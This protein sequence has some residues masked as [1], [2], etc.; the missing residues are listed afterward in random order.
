MKISRQNVCRLLM[1][2]QRILL[3]SHQS[4]D[5][6]TLGSAYAMFYAL[7][8]LGKQ[9]NI[10]CS[11]KI[12]EKYD[13]MTSAAVLDEIDPDLIVAVD[14]ADEGLF[15]K[16]LEPY[17]GRVDLCIDH[18]PSNTRYAKKILLV[19]SASAVCEII[20][21]VVRGMGLEMDPAIADCLYTGICTDTGCFRYANVTPRTHRIAA[22][23]MQAGAQSAM[24]NQIMFDTKSRSRIMLERFA[25]ESIE[26]FYEGK[27]AAVTVSRS[28]ME[29]SGADD[30]DLDGVSS[31]P[32]QIEGVLV[33]ITVRE[34]EPES[35][36]ISIRTQGE[37]NASKI[38]GLF[39]G[40][41]HK[42]AAGCT[43]AGTLP[44]VKKKL[45]EAVGPFLE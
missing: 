2:H 42:N 21:T 3:L 33:G 24:I 15:G 32:R 1:Q 22:A 30:S 14:I 11:D 27:C 6:D 40:G 5:G 23:L 18:H 4:P 16:K 38:C 7:K 9:A 31:M 45:I 19:S 26:Y 13:Y 29:E 44:E 37:I 39:G 35:Y 8:K 41:G 25:M 20:Y 10:L 28:M 34:K 17:R 12:P 43:I 36:K